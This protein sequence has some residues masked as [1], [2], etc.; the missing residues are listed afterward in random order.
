MNDQSPLLNG[1]EGSIL[2]SFA[3]SEFRRT[4]WKY[5]A[6]S[7]ILVI[8]FAFV[9]DFRK[10]QFFSTKYDL[11]L[12]GRPLSAFLARRVGYDQLPYFGSNA[13][14]TKTYKFLKSYDFVI[15]PY[16][17]MTLEYMDGSGVS[18]DDFR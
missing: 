18:F 3:N 14:T 1:S 7:V 5:V 13:S 16:A 2:R 12:D 6:T 15:E 17:P 10:V 9:I 4:F 8:T 11:Q